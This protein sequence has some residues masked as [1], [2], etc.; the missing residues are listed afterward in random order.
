MSDTTATNR[1]VELGDEV[2]LD[3][4]RTETDRA[5]V[6]FYTDGCGICSSMVPV[7]GG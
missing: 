3:A 1:P 7:L 6:A 2:A 5:L 4:F